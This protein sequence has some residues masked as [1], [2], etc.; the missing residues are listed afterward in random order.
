MY[1]SPSNHV[2]FAASCSVLYLAYI[3]YVVTGMWC[4]EVGICDA[5]V[6]CLCQ[7]G[8]ISFQPGAITDHSQSL[9]N[10]DP[11]FK[12]PL[13]VEDPGHRKQVLVLPNGLSKSGERAHDRN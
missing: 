3:A 11:Y 5:R 10:I 1:S 4:C 6:Y 2:I 9:K 7:A 8:R 13:Y 12:S